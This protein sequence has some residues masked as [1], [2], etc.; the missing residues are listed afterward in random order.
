MNGKVINKHIINNASELTLNPLFT[1]IM[2]NL[3]DYRKQY[4]MNG[5]D[6]IIKPDFVYINDSDVLSEKKS[7]QAMKVICLLYTSDAADE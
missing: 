2:D 1:E 6:F 7:A 3:A 5:S 4:Q